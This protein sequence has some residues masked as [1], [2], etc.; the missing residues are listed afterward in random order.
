MNTDAWRAGFNAALKPG[1]SLIRAI[2]P[3]SEW[4]DEQKFDFVSGFLAGSRASRDIELI[5]DLMSNPTFME[6]RE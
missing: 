1:D 2:K 6:T 4:A 3:P 5:E